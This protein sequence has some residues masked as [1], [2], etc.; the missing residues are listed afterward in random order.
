[1]GTKGGFS[2]IGAVRV[3]SHTMVPCPKCGGLKRIESKQCQS[4]IS[5][6]TR[7]PINYDLIQIEGEPCRLLPLTKGLYSII[8]ESDYDGLIQWLWFAVKCSGMHYAARHSAENGKIRRIYLHRFLT[9]NSGIKTDHK[10]RNPLDNRRSNLRTCTSSQNMGNVGLIESNTSGYRG[11]T[12]ARTGWQAQ[13]KIRNG[14]KAVTHYLGKYTDP[15]D[16]AIAYD[17]FAVKVLGEFAWL[18][19]PVNSSS[20]VARG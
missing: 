1:M 2:V 18:N 14:D 19:F 7:P 4:C 10:N 5:A 9:N 20:E 8:C 12:W 16:A 17:A 3:G 15:I 13:L 11:V 6:S